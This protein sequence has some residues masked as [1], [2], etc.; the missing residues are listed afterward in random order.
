MYIVYLEHY[1][2]VYSIL[3]AFLCVYTVYLDHL[4]VYVYSVS[5]AFTCVFTVYLEYYMC[6]YSV[7]GVR[8]FPNVSSCIYLLCMGTPYFSPAIWFL[9]IKLRLSGVVGSKPL[10][11]EP[12]VLNIPSA[13]TLKCSSS[14][15]DD[16]THKIMFIATS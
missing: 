15:C 6:V 2:Y 12:L 16:S 13:V 9:D 11:S 3:G 14:C 4:D 8:N 1:M 7:L 10:D 5:G